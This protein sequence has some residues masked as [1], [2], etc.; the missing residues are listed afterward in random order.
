M[1]KK[2][3]AK[4]SKI[5]R[6]RTAKKSR[7]KKRSTS[8]VDVLTPTVSDEAIERAAGWSMTVEWTH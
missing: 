3:K 8:N 7:P 2:R 4:K 1:A 5:K 6:K